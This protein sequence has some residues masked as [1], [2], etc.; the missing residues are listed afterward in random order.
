MRAIVVK[1]GQALVMHRNKFGHEYYTL[2]GGGIDPGE[3]PETALRR[4]VREESGLFV[5]SGRL[6]FIEEAGDPYGTQYIYLCEVEGGEPKLEEGSEEAMLMDMGN[7]HTPMWVP[8]QEFA[9]LE[10][11]S[12]QLQKAMMYGFQ[13]GFPQ[14]AVELDARYLDNVQAKIAQRGQ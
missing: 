4:E 10:F 11:R 5:K 8:V 1:D 2:L 3:T 7:L 13:Y 12:P 9:K 14:Q 6:V